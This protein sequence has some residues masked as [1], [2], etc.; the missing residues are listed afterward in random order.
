MRPLG[1]EG[2]WPFLAFT[3]SLAPQRNKMSETFLGSPGPETL[4]RVSWESGAGMGKS[5]GA[6]GW[7]Q[8]GD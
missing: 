3:I 7:D 8:E 4:E 2:G 1:R 6:D 5:S